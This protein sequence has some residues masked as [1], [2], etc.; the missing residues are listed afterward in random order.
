MTDTRPL[1]PH[2]GVYRWQIT[3]T[4]S[5]AHRITGVWLAIGTLALVYW[6]VAASTGPD[7]FATAHW[8]FGTWIG[9]ILMWLWT[10]SL[11]Y[12]L[13]NGIRHLFWD[14]GQGFE[15]RTF[16]ISGY[17]VWVLAC[18]LTAMAIIFAYLGGRP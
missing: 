10:F 11:F 16:Y 12:H 14:A 2:V 1:T 9:Q 13:C 8:F 4:M 15:I 7:N 3:M 18:V 5:I 17:G 6:L